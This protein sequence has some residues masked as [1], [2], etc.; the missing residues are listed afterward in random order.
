MWRLGIGGGGSDGACVVVVS[1][2]GLDD[3][4]SYIMKA[5]IA[6]L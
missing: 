6:Q 1:G 2:L 5:C 4:G 3:G